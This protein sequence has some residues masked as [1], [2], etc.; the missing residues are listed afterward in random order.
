M[1]LQQKKADFFKRTIYSKSTLQPLSLVEKISVWERY[2]ESR[3]EQKKMKKMNA[4]LFEKLEKSN[5][6]PTTKPSVPAAATKKKVPLPF[7]LWSYFCNLPQYKSLSQKQKSEKYRAM[8]FD[9]KLA[10]ENEMKETEK[11]EKNDDEEEDD[12]EEKKYTSK[13]RNYVSE[14]DRSNMQ[15]PDDCW[16]YQIKK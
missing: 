2:E 12:E 4:S 11:K 7:K 16:W 14:Y 10:L 8:S 15:N 1:S 13:N 5:I 9:E 6:K 3:K